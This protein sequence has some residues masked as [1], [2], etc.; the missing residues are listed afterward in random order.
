M[1][2][3]EQEGIPVETDVIGTRQHKARTHIEARPDVGAKRL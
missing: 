3:N 2:S 1:D